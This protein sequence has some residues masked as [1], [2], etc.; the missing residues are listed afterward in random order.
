M[1]DQDVPFTNWDNTG[2]VLEPA[3]D[4]QKLCSSLCVG[5]QCSDVYGWTAD[6]CDAQK[7]QFVCQVECKFRRIF[8]NID[9]WH[10]FT[11]D[12]VANYQHKSLRRL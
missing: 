10:S 11:L 8:L 7:Q 4:D 2:D 9:V 12:H 3:A 6:A 1:A 5:P